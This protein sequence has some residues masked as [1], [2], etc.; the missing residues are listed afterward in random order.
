MRTVTHIAIVIGITGLIALVGGSRA[1]AETLVLRNETVDFGEVILGDAGTRAVFVRVNQQANETWQRVYDPAEPFVNTTPDGPVEIADTFAFIFEFFPVKGGSYKDSTMLVRLVDGQP[2]DTIRVLLQGDGRSLSDRKAIRYPLTMTGDFMLWFQDF[3]GLEYVVDQYT[4]AHRPTEPFITAEDPASWD[5]DSIQ[6]GAAFEPTA[7]G[8]FEDSLI[9]VRRLNGTTPLDTLHL[10]LYGFSAEMKPD[11]TVPFTGVTV[12]GVDTLLVFLRLPAFFITREFRY[13]IVSLDPGPM[14]A[15]VDP[16]RPTRRA[17]MTCRIIA[18]PSEFRNVRQRF[19]MRRWSEQTDEIWDSTIINVD[20]LMAPRPIN[21]RLVWDQN[22]IDARIGDTV[23][24][25]LQAVTDD[26]FDAQIAIDDV[27]LD[28]AY[29]PTVFIPLSSPGQSRSVVNDTTWWTLTLPR[30]Q[31]LSDGPVTPLATLRAVI[32]LG[33]ADHSPVHPANATITIKGGEARSVPADTNR[34]NITNVFRYGDGTPRYINPLQ[35]GLEISID[36]NPV[37]GS[38]TLSL[39]NV[40]TGRGACDIID[41]MGQ[42]V[43][44]LSSQVR[45]GTT[46]FTISSGG[47]ADVGLT[48]GSYY[49]RLTVQGDQP[50][51]V[52][53]VVRLL[54]VQ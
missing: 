52:A 48:P 21:Y 43:A 38:A 31:V 27:R 54:I 40:P 30:D 32:A 41:V 50:N 5:G 53:R 33:D 36:P 9:L 46:T 17:V 7:L 13:D 34:M 1:G 18:S 28:I 29:N 23:S 4:V 49:A 20:L 2:Q 11:T 22:P 14:R 6:V 51:S 35:Q 8:V 42:V 3:Y 24:V 44:D 37:T 10:D 45:S 16:T 19:V 25:V 47:G 12:G 26:I 39:E 15:E